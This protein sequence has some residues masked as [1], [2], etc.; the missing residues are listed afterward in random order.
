MCVFETVTLGYGR[1]LHFLHEDISPLIE[2]RISEDEVGRDA[3]SRDG[4]SVERDIP[5]ELFPEYGF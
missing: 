3:A 4:Q 5:T 2:S 1:R